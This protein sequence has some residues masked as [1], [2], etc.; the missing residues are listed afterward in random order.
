MKLWL[1]VRIVLLQLLYIPVYNL[2]LPPLGH[3]DGKRGASNT[4]DHFLLRLPSRYFSNNT[5]GVDEQVVGKQFF[6]SLD[7]NDSGQ[8]EEEQVLDLHD[9]N[10]NAE[11]QNGE[12]SSNNSI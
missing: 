12:S 7:Q 10:Y 6:P 3:L 8:A 2:H 5:V 4:I 11:C 9:L 1:S